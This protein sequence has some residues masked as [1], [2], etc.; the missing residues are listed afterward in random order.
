MW[1]KYPL[2]FCLT[3]KRKDC[4]QMCAC[5][6][7][8]LPQINTWNKADC[9]ISMTLCTWL[10]HDIWVMVFT[11]S[12]WRVRATKYLSQSHVLN[13]CRCPPS[14]TQ[15]CSHQRSLLTLPWSPFCC[16]WV[17]M[18]VCA[19]QKRRQEHGG[20]HCLHPRR[21]V[22]PSGDSR[23]SGFLLSG[24]DGPA[25]CSQGPQAPSTHW[26]RP[27]FSRPGG[28]WTYCCGLASGAFGASLGLRGHPAVTAKT[29]GASS[30]SSHPPPNSPLNTHKN[31]HS[32]WRMAWPS[33]T[34]FGR[35]W[36]HHQA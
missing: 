12:N 18:C 5:G 23:V 11:A 1:L 33:L 10:L 15:E 4:C 21:C 22:F 26:P 28:P 35:R 34:T 13:W 24:P 3:E 17:N 6:R 9:H 2:R 30:L 7:W 16:H 20:R 19:R 32:P 29:I 25:S 8:N 36:P 31:T 14:D 27:G